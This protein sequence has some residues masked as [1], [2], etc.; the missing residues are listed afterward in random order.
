VS[1]ERTRVCAERLRLANEFCEATR[2]YSDLV[3]EMRDMIAGGLESEVAVVRGTSRLA[4]ETVERARLALARHEAN[5]SCQA[6]PSPAAFSNLLLPAE[7]AA[8]RKRLEHELAVAHEKFRIA[9]SEL[10]DVIKTVPSGIP[11][12]D[13]TFRI[14]QAGAVRRLAY[15]EY[16]RALDRC[17]YFETH[18][19]LPDPDALPTDSEIDDPV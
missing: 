2:I 17:R 12:G 13:G 18:G 4:W 6:Y 15:K 5:H 14:T 3:I 9:S 11:E 16:R 19:R 10:K 7:S 1:N 8:T